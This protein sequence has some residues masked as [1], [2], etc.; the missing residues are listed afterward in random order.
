MRIL[1]NKYVIFGV[2]MLL[3]A[4]IAFFIVP[5]QNQKLAEGENVVRVVKKVEANSL[6]SED[7]LKLEKSIAPPQKSIKSKDEIVGKYSVVPLYPEDNLIID[8]FSDSVLGND[9]KL[10]EI[11]GVNTFAISISLKTL[12]ASVSGK[13][14]AGD[15][16]NVL[17]FN[18]EQKTL[19]DYATLKH[20]E[21]LSVT[22]NKAKDLGSESAST[23]EE[24][25]D[26]DNVVPAT[27]T[28]KVNSE[29]AKLLVSAE[30]TGSLHIVFAGR[31]EVASKLLE[32][33][34]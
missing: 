5:K 30:N 18:T 8:R 17:G 16:V 23:T 11:D 19:V 4:I 12:A 13:I 3:S 32:G 1:K 22:N 27:I 34:L 14:M 9:R 24:N 2:C 10:Y 28:L 21:V 6:I 7:M 20:I 25:S 33:G 15:V 31:G 29:Q 26:A